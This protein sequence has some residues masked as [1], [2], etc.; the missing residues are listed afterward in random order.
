MSKTR[1]IMSDANDPFVLSQTESLWRS[2][3]RIQSPHIRSEPPLQQSAS[4]P[5]PTNPPAPK[6]SLPSSTPVNQPDP[7][8]CETVQAHQIPES[9]LK[10]V[11]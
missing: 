2:I 3:Q 6:P 11:H 8:P 5:R 7:S 1:S 9:R 10:T 4:P